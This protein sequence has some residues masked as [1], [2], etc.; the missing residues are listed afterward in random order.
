MLALGRGTLRGA[1]QEWSR[2]SARLGG[3]GGSQCAEFRDQLLGGP[4]GKLPHNSQKTNIFLWKIT[5][6]NGKIHYFY[7]HFQ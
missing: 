5:I 4:L 1:R 2:L 3:I 6:F 7:G